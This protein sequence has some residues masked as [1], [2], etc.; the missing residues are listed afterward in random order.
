MTRR[1]ARRL[2]LLVAVVALASGT[3]AAPASLART[4]D[5]SPPAAPQP[6]ALAAGQLQLK[7]I[8][9][10]LSQPIGI[11]NAGDGSNRLFIVQRRGVVRVVNGTSLQGAA[12]MNISSRVSQSGSERGLLGLAFDPDFETNRRLFV[13]YTQPDGDI[14]IARYLADPGLATVNESSEVILLQIE[15]STY[16][17]HNG[18]QLAFG[19]DGYL[20]AATGDGGGSGDPLNNG[21]D[22]TDE[23]LGKIL[24][25]N[26]DGS[27]YTNPPD[28]PF[29][30]QT[31]DD[32]IWDYGLRNPWRFSFDRA[33]NNL[34]IADVGQNNWEE[35]N[36]EPASS[37]GGVNYGWDDMEG[38]H[39]HE[40]GCSFAGKTLPIA[41]Y[42]HSLGCSVTGGYVYR[43]TTQ[44]DLVGNYVLADYCSGRLWTIPATGTALTQRLDTS[45]SIT[46]FGEGESGELYAV[47]LG[48]GRLYRVV[49]PEFSDILASSFIDDIHWLLYEGITFG[50]DGTRFCP[51]EP[52]TRGEM[53]SFLSRVLNLPTSPTDYFTDDEG[54]VH[55]GAI[56]E[57]A[58]AGITGG[59]AAG[60]YCPERNVTRGEMATF[61]V[62]ALDLPPSA[63]DYFTDDESS[64]HEA[65]INAFR[66]AGLTTGC[67][68]TTYCP[69][70][71][72]TREQMAAFLHR[73]FD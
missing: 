60:Q 65:N 12:F 71:N 20:Y 47:D 37:P 62:R 36:R 8:T 68:A 72:V 40:S 51:T 30:G 22:I 19:P 1:V 42:S 55:E 57:I 67:T 43:G 52:V 70:S 31:G 10:G 66:A 28:N 34:W 56:N 33:T 35:I 23:L 21:Q 64:T 26:V 54:S 18:G 6:A 4:L 13:Y 9:S 2:G 61:L 5:A 44:L 59:C 32:E 3:I 14:V 46:S 27:S 41:E 63:T 24:R 58:H 25:L 50:C 45:L 15:H 38:K 7:F 11:V 48:G 49:A 69:N 39:C 17:N 53:A 16:S 73:A 29:V